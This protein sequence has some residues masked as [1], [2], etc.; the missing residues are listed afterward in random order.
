MRVRWVV[1]VALG[2]VLV[3]GSVPAGAANPLLVGGDRLISG[4]GVVDDQRPVVAWNASAE[5]FL[6]VWMRCR[7][8]YDCDVVGRRVGAD[9]GPVGGIFRIGGNYAVYPAVAWN[10]TANEYLVVWQDWRDPGTRGEWDIFGRRV[11]ADGRPLGRGFRISGRHATGAEY[12]PAVAWNAAANQYLVVWRD[13]RN[14]ATV[15]SEI[16]GRRVGADGKTDGSDFRISG[17]HAKGTFQASVA[18]HGTADEYLVVWDDGRAGATRFGDIYGR[19]IGSDG[20]P[21]GGDFRISDYRA[22]GGKES[23][24]VAWSEA[25]GRY[26]VVW[27]DGRDRDARGIDIRGRRVDAEG[28]TIARD[29][30]INRKT[31]G[32]RTTLGDT[33]PAVAWSDTAR[34]YLVVWSDGRDEATRGFDIEGRRVGANGR[35]IGGDIRVSGYRATAHDRSP[36]VAWDQTSGQYLVVWEDWRSEPDRDRD[37]YGRRVA[38]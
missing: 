4:S 33:D 32:L 30:R 15:G 12:A 26:L 21:N 3:C 31:T 36:G 16:F 7:D 34:Q 24:A 25:T 13:Q 2:L 8:L 28:T 6:V 9:G 10:A 27:A 37:I 17:R 23:P 22:T 35:P 18:A 19:R 20:R 5:E 29:F 1:C 14:L 11:G 38:G